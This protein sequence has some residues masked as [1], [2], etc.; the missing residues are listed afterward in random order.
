M[1]H[2]LCI[3]ALGTGENPN[4]RSHWLFLIYTPTDDFG[5]IYQVLP[6]DLERLWYQY[7]L[8]EATTIKTPQAVGMC[9]IA[10]L[11]AKTRLEVIRVIQ[12]EPAPRDGKRRCQDWTVDVMISLEVEELV[13]PGT[14]EKWSQRVGMTARELAR[15]CGEDW[16]EFRP[17]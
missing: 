4:H 5:D 9:T 16:V 8:R 7:D 14:A 10:V 6:I 13:Q 12:N 11:D 17:L 1:T 3:Q 2:H 15:S